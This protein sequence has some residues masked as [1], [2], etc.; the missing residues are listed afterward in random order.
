ML[1][2]ENAPERIFTLPGSRLE[3]TW[4]WNREKAA[5]QESFTEDRFVPR[6]FFMVISDRVA[7]V[8]VWPDAIPEL[9]PEVD[10]LHIGRDELAP[11]P[12]WRARKKDEMLVPFGQ[13]ATDLA[14]YATSD[15]KLP[16]YKL[17][18]PNVPE[19]LRA[20]VRN[21]KPTGITG[22]GITVDQILN[23]EVVAKVRNH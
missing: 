23:E 17:P 19:H 5:V 15:Y 21:L 4:Q 8:A 7:T 12:F 2:G 16:A 20:I 11:K 9:V 6:V 10:F 14:P 1:R 18:T 13:L 3:S 22:E